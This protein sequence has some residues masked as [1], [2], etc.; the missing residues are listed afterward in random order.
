MKDLSPVATTDE[1]RMAYRF[2]LGRDSDE[3]GLQYFSG[4]ANSQRLDIHQIAKFLI[5]SE[6]FR[7]KNG[8][9]HEPTE[10]VLDGYSIFVRT[11][12]RDIGSAIA[13]GTDYEPHVTALI[14]REVDRGDTFMDL[15]ANIGFFTMMAAHQVGPQGK[16]IAIE[17]MDKNLQLIYL[18]IKKNGYRNVEIF[19]FGA[20]DQP[21]LVSIVTDANT[22]NAL[23]QS[24]SSSRVPSLHAPTRTLDWMCPDLERL[25]FLKMDIEGH[26]VLAWRGAGKLLARCKPKIATEFHPL[27]MRENAGIDCRD[28]V[29]MMFEYSRD[30][31]VLVSADKTIAC[32]SYEQVMNCWQEAD[33]RFGGQGS[34]HLDLFLMPKS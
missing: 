22:S 14:K 7:A 24:A 31:R 4:M 34:T 26:E 27:A 18:G 30:I 8:G 5:S 12:D 29:D 13:R 33:N 28:Y 9:T 21:G 19:P 15:G 25:D 3:G 32:S 11:S 16:V 2:I 10:L 6:E 1:I 20:S 23:V 17:P